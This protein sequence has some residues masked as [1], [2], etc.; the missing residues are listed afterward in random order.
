V[1]GVSVGVVG[2]SPPP[3]P[4]P[5]DPLLGGLGAGVVAVGVVAVGVVADCCGAGAPLV[6]VAGEEL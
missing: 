6:G 5:V 4:L 2:V 1:V 3:E